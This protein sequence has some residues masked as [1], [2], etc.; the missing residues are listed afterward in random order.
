MISRHQKADGLFGEQEDP[1]VYCTVC[2]MIILPVVGE[3]ILVH[4]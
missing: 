3:W 2:N 1:A 4:V